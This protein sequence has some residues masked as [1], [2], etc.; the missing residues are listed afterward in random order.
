M[1]QAIRAL[2]MFRVILGPVVAAIAI[3]ACAAPAYSQPPIRDRALAFRLAVDTLYT[4]NALRDSLLAINAT[5]MAEADRAADAKARVELLDARASLV[6][7]TP[8]EP[9]AIGQGLELARRIHD[10]PAECRFLLH[11]GT[12]AQA[13]GR[14]A[15]MMALAA[16]LDPMAVEL[17]GT[18][19]GARADYFVGRMMIIGAGRTADA[20]VRFQRAL[21]VF[22]AAGSWDRVSQCHGGLGLVGT[23]LGEREAGRA[24]FDTAIT[25]A[26][27]LGR[28]DLLINHLGNRGT[29]EGTAGRYDRTL[30]DYQEMAAIA[31][32]LGR[33][34]QRGFAHQAMGT[35]L[36]RLTRYP[37]A[38]AQGESLI[39]IGREMGSADLAA[40][41]HIVVAFAQGS[42][43]RP[44]EAAAHCRIV[45]GMGDSIEVI[46]RLD[47]ALNL[48]TYLVALDSAATGLAILEGIEPLALRMG[49]NYTIRVASGQSLCLRK[50]G[51]WAEAR[52]PLAS[53]RPLMMSE[54]AH[55]YAA[56]IWS[57]WAGI[58]V[59]L[60]QADSAAVHAR[61]ARDA[62]LR[63]RSMLQD[64]AWREAIGFLGHAIAGVEVRRHLRGPG[65]EEERATRA[66]DAIEPFRAQ[67]LI[68]RVAG[69]ITD[70][71]FARGFATA[72]G[73]RASLREGELWLQWTVT[74]D[75]S[76]L[77]AIDRDRISAHALGAPAESLE[78]RAR[79]LRRLVGSRPAR[80][81]A[82]RAAA[83]AAASRGLASDLM[84]PAVERIRA[85]KR[86]LLSPDGALCQLP[87]ATLV[88]EGAFDGR[89]DRNPELVDVASASM[90]TLHRS[91]TE[92]PDQANLLLAASGPAPGEGAFGGRDEVVWLGRSFEGVTV[93]ERPDPAPGG[94]QLDR[95][96]GLHFAA[97]AQ[98][99]DRSPWRS[100]LLLGRLQDAESDG[101]LQ[102]STIATM[103]LP[104][105]IAVLSSCETAYG[106][107][108]S[109]EGLIGLSTAFQSAGVPTVVA[110]LWKV[111]DRVTADWMKAFY[112][113]LSKGATASRALRQAQDAIAAR[114]GTRDPYYWAGFVLLGE[115][116]ATLAMVARPAYG[117]W[118]VAALAVLGL[119]AIVMRMRRRP[120]PP[121]A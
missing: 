55:S 88:A 41:G 19:E 38:I 14:S 27:R 89:T 73:L 108:L 23:Y 15:E 35:I 9:E 39:A 58:D 105:A 81:E 114:G 72:A 74:P 48:A 116:D 31:A 37:E 104:A 77:F 66:F 60:G 111:D 46:Q 17:A 93:R 102:A 107:I 13:T 32:R 61:L 5:L 25:I 94:L 42:E 79:E 10:R 7:G 18:M 28:D 20:K 45:V 33:P 1:R 56:W 24:H 64:E 16:Q 78:S 99:D 97:H 52:R 115:P 67:T 86:L 43:D 26:R 36:T 49:E 112:R 113:A 8:A 121:A 21:P 51:R 12:L 101:Y 11:L 98:V 4:Q 47:G 65:S 69:K 57:D 68:E 75:T 87:F 109:G 3:A 62:F 91:R 54:R 22:V 83:L 70:S 71:T 63:T 50:M 96:Q 110:T 103:R 85:S 120:A 34:Q 2:P 106:A 29:L 80:G 95:Y 30:R 100:G 119:A 84:A 53:L 118:V 6:A 59:S 90:L 92:A 82:P 40:R 117:W 44:R 76:V